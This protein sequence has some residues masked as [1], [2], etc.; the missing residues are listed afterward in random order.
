MQEK[1]VI[2]IEVILVS[3]MLFAMP[4]QVCSQIEKRD[5]IAIDTLSIW[6]EQD[7]QGVTITAKQIKP[8]T[9]G[10]KAMIAS[11]KMFRSRNLFDAML[12]LPG[13]F[14]ED[15]RLKA[16]G[17]SITMIYV[18]GKRVSLD[19]KQLR[20]YLR[21]FSAKGV[22]SV[23][24]ERRE[25]NSSYIL[26]VKTTN[27]NGGGQAT[28]GLD[29]SAGNVSDFG[30]A[31]SL[32][33]IRT[34]GKFS[35]QG[36]V[37]YTPSEFM[38]RDYSKETF[39][40]SPLAYRNECGTFSLDSRNNTN[41]MF[42]MGYV[43]NA[44]HSLSFNVSG[45]YNSRDVNYKT[46]NVL[47]LDEETV[48]DGKTN[49]HL[50]DNTF[51][52]SLDYIGKVGDLGIK[53]TMFGALQSFRNTNWR[54]QTIEETTSDINVFQLKKNRVAGFQNNLSWYIN[55]N[56][57]LSFLTSY[58]RWNNSLGEEQLNSTADDASSLYRY[59]ENNFNSRFSFTQRVGKF[60]L[61]GGLL[62][63]W[64]STDFP[65]LAVEKS[66]YSYFLPNVR[67]QY[68]LD[69]EKGQ[70]ID[71]TYRKRLVLPPFEKQMPQTTW[72]S[73]YEK[74]SGNPQIDPD[75]IHSLDLTAQVFGFTFT[76]GYLYDKGAVMI[77]KTEESGVTN[78]TFGNGDIKHELS[79]RIDAPTVKPCKGWMLSS[80]IGY[81][82]SHESYEDLTNCWNRLTLNVSS[83]HELPLGFS[84]MMN[85]YFLT[86]DRSLRLLNANTFLGSASLSHSFLKSRLNMSLDV[87]YSSNGRTRTMGDTFYAISKYDRGILKVSLSGRYTLRWGKNVKHV[88]KNENSNLDRL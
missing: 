59:H 68:V 62:W 60:T 51:Q 63:N 47:T 80:A 67:V 3:V 44:D 8:T 42:G 34:I 79:L 23:E 11:E 28:I 40:S 58:V 37:R 12:M 74:E 17:K 14:C 32:N 43:F 15:E 1:S 36:F 78:L 86:K 54:E 56:Q 29:A 65:E 4:K 88:R 16:Y 76:G 53:A 27:A 6:K 75:V 2:L 66:Y 71:L 70:V 5:T 7:L 20:D 39:Y 21:S 24:L 61:V 52:T 84:L 82:W 57:T 49:M 26:R 18:D 73:E 25:N 30:L 31:P 48:S 41:Y 81:K 55:K 72:Q 9:T 46:H 64:I 87:N 50:R 77:Y 85:A 33:L 22:T 45:R 83:M 19:E 69:A 10:Y 38:S 35:Y 13:L